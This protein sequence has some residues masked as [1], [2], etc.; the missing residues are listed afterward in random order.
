MAE[1]RDMKHDKDLIGHCWY[2]EGESQL[3]RNAGSL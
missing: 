1:A 2:G 3:V